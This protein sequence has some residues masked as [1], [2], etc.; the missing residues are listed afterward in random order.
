MLH[1]AIVAVGYEAKKNT[2]IQCV[3][4]VC[5]SW[6][7]K[8]DDKPKKP[9]GSKIMVY[10][11]ATNPRKYIYT[12]WTIMSKFLFF[13]FALGPYTDPGSLISKVP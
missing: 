12:R 5:N 13:F 4:K 2:Q 6:M 11:W 9:V 8:T 1:S 7:C 10:K 3:G